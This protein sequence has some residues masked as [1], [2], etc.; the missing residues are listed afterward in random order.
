MPKM[1]PDSSWVL[2]RGGSLLPSARTASAGVGEGVCKVRT[3]E[4]NDSATVR[5]RDCT[6]T[7]ATGVGSSSGSNSELIALRERVRYPTT[8]QVAFGL[9]I[10]RG[11]RPG[12][13]LRWVARKMRR[14]V[15]VFRL[16]DHSDHVRPNARCSTKYGVD[17]LALVCLV[18]TQVKVYGSGLSMCITQWPVLRAWSLPVPASA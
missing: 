11:T 13:R 14:S 10:P 18:R 5:A 4:E 1:V 2:A 16:V 3:R 12:A 17:T 7:G 6:G 9:S 15:P 8:T